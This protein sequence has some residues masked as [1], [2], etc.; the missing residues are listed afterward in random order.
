MKSIF[1]FIPYLK[2]NSKRTTALNVKPKTAKH[3]EGKTKIP[4]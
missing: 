2:V 3:F 4:F 1:N